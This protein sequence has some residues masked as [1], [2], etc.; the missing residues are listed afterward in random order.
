M[1]LIL[2]V[3]LIFLPIFDYGCLK[4]IDFLDPWIIIIK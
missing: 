2:A 3:V 1:V 4:P